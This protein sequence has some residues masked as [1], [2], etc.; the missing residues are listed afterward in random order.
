MEKVLE[1]SESILNFLG[2]LI[3]VNRFRVEFTGI[4]KVVKR[5]IDNL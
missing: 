5:Y 3:K 1:S 4:E 2:E